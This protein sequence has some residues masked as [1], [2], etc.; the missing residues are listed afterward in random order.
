MIEQ[1]EARVLLSGDDFALLGTIALARGGAGVSAFDFYRDAHARA[2]SPHLQTNQFVINEAEEEDDA[3]PIPLDPGADIGPDAPAVSGTIEAANFNTNPPLNNNL[4]FIPPDPSGAVGPNHVVNVVNAVIQFFTKTG[5][6]QNSQSLSSFFAS[7][8]PANSLFDPK[9]IYDQYNGRFVVEADE[10]VDNGATSSSSTSRVLIAVSDDSD[11]NG[12]WYETALNTKLTINSTTRWLDYP[13]LA[14]DANAIYL[15]GNMFGFSGGGYG[16]SRLWIINKSGLYTGGSPSSVN[17]YDPSTASGSGLNLFTLQPA[18]MYGTAPAGVGTFLMAADVVDLNTHNDFLGVIKITNPLSS[19]SFTYNSIA[20]GNTHN[21][22]VAIPTAPQSGTTTNVATND[23]RLINVVWRN[24]NLYTAN[25]TNPPSGPEAGQATARWYRIADNGSSTP[26]LADTGIVTG[27][28]IAPSTYTFFPSVNVDSSGNMAINFAASASTI[29]PGAYYTGRLAT[30]AAGTVQTPT[31]TLAAGLDYYVRKFSGT[32]NRWG[33]YTSVAID[34]TDNRTFWLYNEYAITR[35]SATNG[36]DGRW[37][38][39]WGDFAFPLPVSATPGTPDLVAASDTGTSSTDNTTKL[40]NSAAG[41]TLQFSVTGT[42][43]GA[44]VTIYSDGTAIGS[45]TA[46]GT[47]TT[48]TT[49][50]SFDLVDGTHSI[51]AKQTESGKAQSAASGALSIKVDTVAPT[52][53]NTS[54]Q[55]DVAPQQ[56]IYTFSE[57][58]SGTLAASDIAVA[59]V[60]AGTN[61]ALSAPSWNAATNT[62][63]FNFSSSPVANNNYTATLTGSG[64][65]DVAGNPISGNPVFPFFFLA[66]DGNRNKTVEITDFNI[67]AAN[68]GKTGQT[69]SQGNYDYSADGTV[70]ITDFNI[71]AA[72]FGKSLP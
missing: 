53:T 6:A 30:D 27:E 18:Q 55:F 9:V 11:P 72:N 52:I 22:A 17:V 14:V 38:T 33:D 63:T 24:N 68:F 12:T 42:V 60:P 67:L 71:L 59:S 1:L 20:L 34:P 58:V 4:L 32:S 47:T 43:S 25:T 28:D 5:T 45:A 10:K 13:G 3:P 50:G 31:Q 70:T 54:F 48:V 19:P 41:S 44:T 51:T 35:G 69:W 2:H 16:G 37:G 21:D 66:A 15:T 7:Q 64:V 40:D 56:L 62:A 49:N 39:R 26:T 8:S 57:D 23:D 61:P 29:H 36:Q 65:T 46:A